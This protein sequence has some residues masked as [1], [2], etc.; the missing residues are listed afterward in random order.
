[1]SLFGDSGEIVMFLLGNYSENN[2]MQTIFLMC[3]L[4]DKFFKFP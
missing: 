1:M 4:N 2:S 3:A